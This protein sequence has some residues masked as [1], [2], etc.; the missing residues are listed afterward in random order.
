ML[1]DHER[2]PGQ[3][4]AVEGKKNEAKKILGVQVKRETTFWNMLAIL[5]APVI[6]VIAGSY[7]NAVMPF[8]LQDEDYFNVPFK[9]VGQEAGHVI[10]WG[11]LVS[12]LVTPWIG[13]IY[14]IL[15]R[16]WFI[17]PSCY[18]LCL[19]LALIPYSAPHFW[20]LYVFRSVMSCLINT[21]HVNPLIIDYIKKDSRG[22]MIGFA[23]L[24]FVLGELGMVVLFSATR[25]LNI[26]QQFWVPA[27]VIA[28]AST[29]LIFLV[30]E[31]SV[32]KKSLR[33]LQQ[34]NDS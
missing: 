28:L 12:T 9:K 23:S 2:E 32:V 27:V 11:Y 1:K 34:K 8:L 33:E 5:V 25:K 24:G 22:H 17:I 30:R 16:F 3:S 7:V 21:I 4:G 29:S 6:S 10:F 18:V 15:G 14:D 31:P 19:Q 13:F 26:N 20:L